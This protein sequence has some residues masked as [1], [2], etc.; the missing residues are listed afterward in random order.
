MS[1]IYKYE[2]AGHWIGSIV[3]VAA[4]DK[5]EAIDLINK[6]LLKGGLPKECTEDNIA[7]VNDNVI[8]FND[9]TY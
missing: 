5:S 6:E 2:G 7:E 3:I 4:P 8:Y 1:K 9:G